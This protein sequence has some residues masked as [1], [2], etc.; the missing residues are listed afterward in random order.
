MVYNIAY[1]QK[2][3]TIKISYNN[4]LSYC[5][6]HIRIEYL[7]LHNGKAPITGETFYYPQKK[8]RGGVV[9]LFYLEGNHNKRSGDLERDKRSPSLSFQRT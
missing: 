1:A 6:R 7:S 5:V 3:Q 4:G 2:K 8:N 9:I